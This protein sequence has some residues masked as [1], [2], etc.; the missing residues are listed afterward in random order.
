MCEADELLRD[1]V[2]AVREL[3]RVGAGLDAEDACVL[4]R[5]VEG[6]GCVHPVVSVEDRL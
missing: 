4:V 1:D 3:G 6:R 2:D 5:V